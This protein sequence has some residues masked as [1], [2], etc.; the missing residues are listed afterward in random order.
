MMLVTPSEQCFFL[1]LE[2]NMSCFMWAVLLSTKGATADAIRQVQA[3]AEKKSGCRFWV[4]CT[5]SGGEFVAYSMDEGIQ[6]HFSAPYSPQQNGV[7]ERGNKTM[8]STAH[9]AKA[10]GNAGQTLGGGGHDSSSSVQSIANEKLVGQDHVRG[11]AW[12]LVISRTSSHVQL[13]RLHQRAEP[14]GEA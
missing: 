11:M 12:M 3:A 9:I 6:H 13:P 2:N 5:H 7:I 10:N 4:L 1:L 14:G 8:V